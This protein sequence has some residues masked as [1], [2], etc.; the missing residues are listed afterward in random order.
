MLKRSDIE[1]VYA[2][3]DNMT[4]IMEYYFEDEELQEIAV[5]GFYYG[6]PSEEKTREYFLSQKKQ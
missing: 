1:T 4:F 5:V 2:S 3:D 6:E